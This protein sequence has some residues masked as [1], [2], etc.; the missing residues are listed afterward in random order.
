ML[1]GCT[2]SPVHAPAPVA[3]DAGPPHDAGPPRDAT[4]TLLYVPPPDMGC[5]TLVSHDAGPPGRCSPILGSGEL[6]SCP[7]GTIV[8]GT[9]AY[10]C[11]PCTALDCGNPACCATAVCANAT[12][13]R[14]VTCHGLPASCGGRANVDCDDFPEDCDEPCCPCTSC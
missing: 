14:A 5:P 9:A 13:C 2:A 8:H 12:A 1:A 6:Q 4:T 11:C 10:E 7:D 3:R